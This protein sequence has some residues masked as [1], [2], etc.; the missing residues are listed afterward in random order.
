MIG[1]LCSSGDGRPDRVHVG[2]LAEQVDRNDRLGGARDPRGRRTRTEVERR[3]I[4]I[5]EHRLAPSRQTALAVAKNVKLGRITSSPGP[6]PSAI[7]ASSSASLPEAQAMACLV[8]RVVR[9]SPAP[10]RSQS[11]PRINRPES[12]TRSIAAADLA[13]AA[14]RSWRCTSNSGTAG[15]SEAGS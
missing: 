3:R 8:L 7:S 6:M 12:H 5:D 11:G 9:R 4:D 14:A 2:A 15:K 10:A 13:R 1:R